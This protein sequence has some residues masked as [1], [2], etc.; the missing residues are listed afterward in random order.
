[1]R[2]AAI[3]KAA[4]AGVLL[5]A[6]CT[7]QQ[8]DTPAPPRATDKAPNPSQTSLIAVPIA[9]DIAPLKRALERSVPRT[10]WTIN[11]RERACVKPQAVKVF[12]ERVNVTPPI[13]CTI[14]GQVTRGPLRLR[15]EGRDIVIDVPLTATVKAR[16]ADRVFEGE[17]ATAAAMVRARV[18]IDLTPDWRTSGTARIS[19]GWTKAPGIDFLGRR[20]T[21]TDEADRAL[22]PVVRNIERQVSAEISGLNI[23]AQAGDI[24][25]QAFT[26]L[27]LNRENPPVW[28]RLTPQRIL[29]GGYSIRNQRITLNLGVEAVS[30]TFVAGRPEPTAPT[31]LPDLVREQP[32]PQFDV[33]VPV[34]ADYAQLEPIILR[35]LVK[36]SKRP[37]DL[38][39]IGAVDVT[40]D[41]V[42]AYGTPGNRVAVGIDISAR[43]RARS[44]EPT[45]GRVWLTAKPLTE[46]G[47]AVVR[48]GDVQVSGD[49]DAI[50]GDLLLSIAQRD[51]FAPI[52][53]EALTQNLTKD[54]TELEGKIR[55]ATEER[56]EGAFYI[57]TR[58][59]RIETGQITAYGN[60]LY[61]PVRM[62]GAANVVYR[63]QR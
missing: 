16:D 29:Y 52:I 23:R 13:A 51:S 18:R 36:R 63:P 21:F 46:A 58:I 33:R 48:F 32:V 4:L 41:K 43:A 26:V 15:G 37:F 49:T 17:T 7:R 54:L 57:R 45:R 22:A 53:A 44:G 2:K 61:M 30:E 42:T 6:A 19:Y 35:A 38:P 40:F 5:V 28:L 10:L 20:V 31:P 25:R 9:A 11:R 39:A 1:M 60:G 8:A 47:S 14:V 50:T 34:I 24:W 56:Q 12:G 27:S 62:V 55:R 3:L 59:D